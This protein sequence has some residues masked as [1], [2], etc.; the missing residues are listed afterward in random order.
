VKSPEERR[1]WALQVC[2]LAKMRLTPVREKILTFLAA[3]RV[4]VSF[5]AV[6]QAG[7]IRGVCDAAT[8]YRTL[9]LLCELEVIRQ[10]GLPNKI[11]Y[12]VL[13]VPGESSH[14]LICRCCCAI[15]E[16]PA[17]ESGAALEAEVVVAQGYTRLYHELVFFGICP[18]CQKHPPG[19]VCAKVQPRMR[20]NG[21]FKPGRPES[22]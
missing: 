14:F 6:T 17:S 8:V 18:A 21:R 2:L 5:D 7:D 10:V 16:L 15:T 13:N 20:L 4:P 1:L 11:S 22:N 19:V 3:Q 12:F 9:M